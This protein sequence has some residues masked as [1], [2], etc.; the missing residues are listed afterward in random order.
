MKDWFSVI[1]AQMALH[2]DI[3]EILPSLYLRHHSPFAWGKKKLLNVER[4][5]NKIYNE[6]AFSI[7]AQKSATAYHSNR[8]T[9]IEKKL[10]KN[11]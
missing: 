5:R 7:A 2:L 4:S 3:W 10:L 1:N 6:T 9:Q 11:Y 8:E